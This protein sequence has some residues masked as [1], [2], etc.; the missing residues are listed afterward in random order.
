GFRTVIAPDGGEAVSRALVARTGSQCGSGGGLRIA[1]AGLA[2]R[3]LLT[4]RHRPRCPDGLPGR[5]GQRVAGPVA[6]ATVGRRY[7]PGLAVRPGFRV[8]GGDDGSAPGAGGWVRGAGAVAGVAG[9]AAGDGG[10]LGDRLGRTAAVV[11]L[12]A[13]CPTRRL[14]GVA[15][16]VDRPA[17][18]VARTVAMA[19]AIT[20]RGGRAAGRR[21]V[22]GP[23][24]HRLHAA[25]GGRVSRGN[26]RSADAGPGAGGA[27][28]AG[29]AG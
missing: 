19:A 25:G 16:A 6:L 29:H 1:G 4:A 20:G 5:A 24:Q 21:P 2:R 15:A 3:R 23:G 9:L 17:V 8:Q 26:G 12:A 18:D 22:A 10:G 27:C 11:V 7:L 14:A 13:Q 28:R